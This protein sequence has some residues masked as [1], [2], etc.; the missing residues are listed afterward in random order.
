MAGNP[1][2]CTLKGEMMAENGVK[3]TAA[4]GKMVAGAATTFESPIMANKCFY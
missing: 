2:K 3:C 1:A 4:G